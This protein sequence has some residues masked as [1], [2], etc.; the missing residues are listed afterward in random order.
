MQPSPQAQGTAAAAPGDESEQV[1]FSGHPALLPGLGSLLIAIFT[2]G[3]ALLYLLIKQRGRHYR[4]TTQ[5][6]VLDTGLFSKRMEQIDLYRIVDYVVERPFSQRI[7][8][9]GNLVIE[10]MDTTSPTLRLHALP[11]DIVAL[12]E[13]VRTATESE[14]RRRGVRVVDY[15]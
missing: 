14:K 9:T 7:M 13:K 15:E 11:T 2:L 4:I 10:A 5:R 12:Y 6:I 1:L 3:L 8:G